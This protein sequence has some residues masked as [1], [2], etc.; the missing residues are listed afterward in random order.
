MSPSPK[1]SPE[2]QL[3]T[4][5]PSIS[6]H[7]AFHTDKRRGLRRTGPSGVCG[8]AGLPRSH[9]HRAHCLC[10]AADPRHRG[11]S[12]APITRRILCGKQSGDVDRS[13]GREQFGL[14]PKAAACTPMPARVL[15]LCLLIP[16]CHSPKHRGG[17][18]GGLMEAGGTSRGWQQNAPGAW[19]DKLGTKSG[20]QLETNREGG[21]EKPRVEPRQI[22]SGGCL[23]TVSG[24]TAGSSRDR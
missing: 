8:H 17:P 19:K 12:Q 13:S 9:L 3:L 20:G 6:W 1:S 22:R 21:P 2:T 11:S 14:A 10:P 24:D 15:S 16:I 23:E 4:P 7:L 18:A 5:N